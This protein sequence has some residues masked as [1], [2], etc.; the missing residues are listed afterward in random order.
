MTKASVNKRRS[1]D[2]YELMHQSYQHLHA[3]T[4]L[5]LTRKRTAEDN[6]IDVINLITQDKF[7]KEDICK[8]ANY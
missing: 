6:T 5:K 3:D 4:S 8:K 1:E 7:F 2:P